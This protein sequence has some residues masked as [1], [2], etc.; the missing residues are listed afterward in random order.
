[1]N[2]FL[3]ILLGGIAGWLATLFTKTDEGNGI[4][5]NIIIGVVGAFIGGGLFSFF[6]G[7]DITGFNLYSLFVATIGAVILLTIIKMV[8]K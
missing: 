1:M 5:N 7:N 2:F 4:V 8:R 3:W 6:G